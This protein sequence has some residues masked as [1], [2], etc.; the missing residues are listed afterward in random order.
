[1][2]NKKSRKSHFWS[3]LSQFISDHVESAK[4][5]ILRLFEPQNDKI[6][7]EQTAHVKQHKS[8]KKKTCIIHYKSFKNSETLG[9]E[10]R[11]QVAPHNTLAGCRLQPTRPCLL[12]RYIHNNIKIFFF[13]ELFIKTN[14]HLLD[15][16]F[17]YALYLINRTDY[18]YLLTFVSLLLPAILPEFLILH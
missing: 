10:P 2:R 9:F 16:G 5:W 18:N 11:M 14:P 12:L 7:S 8:L 17:V 1:M 4:D 15:K 6:T 13:K 3:S